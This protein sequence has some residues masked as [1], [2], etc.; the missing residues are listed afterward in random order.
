MLRYFEN[1]RQPAVSTDALE[2]VLATEPLVLDDFN[3]VSV[4]VQKERN[5]LHPAVSQ[6]LLPGHIQVLESL[7]GSLEVID[8]DASQRVSHMPVNMQLMQGTYRCAQNPE[9]G[10]SRCDS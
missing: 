6:P 5:I 4:R 8:R 2:V 1:A 10:H 7:T 9:A 3:P